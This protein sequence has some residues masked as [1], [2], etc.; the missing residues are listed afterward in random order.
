MDPGEVV[1]GLRHLEGHAAGEGG[2]PALVDGD[3]LE[4]GHGGARMARVDRNI[5]RVGAF[6]LMAGLTPPRDVIY[7]CV[8]LAKRYGEK[9]TPR[10]VNG[11]LDQLCRNQ[12][13]SL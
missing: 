2:G 12:G 10:F 11:V 8:E 13:I 1:L 9:Q 3:L 6:E 4:G 5:L 7:D